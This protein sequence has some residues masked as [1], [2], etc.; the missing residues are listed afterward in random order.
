MSHNLTTECNA[1]GHFGAAYLPRDYSYQTLTSD[2]LSYRDVDLLKVG[3]VEI[4]NEVVV[5]FS[6]IEMF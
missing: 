3:L 4:T 1:S 6:H 5:K 2:T